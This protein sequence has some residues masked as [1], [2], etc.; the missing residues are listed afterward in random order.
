[1]YMEFL[2]NCNGEQLYCAKLRMKTMGWMEAFP[3]ITL[4]NDNY[5]KYS[6][7]PE[8]LKSPE[9]FKTHTHTHTKKKNYG[10]RRGGKKLCHH[11]PY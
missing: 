7:M 9:M 11:S 2:D 1:M 8:A 5:V 6:V 3:P 10:N 4:A